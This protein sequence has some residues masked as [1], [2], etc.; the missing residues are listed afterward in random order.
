MRIKQIAGL[1]A[2]LDGLLS[3]STPNRIPFVNGAGDAYTDS[4]NLTFNSGT[5]TLF[6]NNI[7]LPTVGSTLSVGLG[8]ARLDIT[9]AAFTVGD[10]INYTFDYGTYLWDI[11]YNNTTIVNKV[12]AGTNNTNVFDFQ[13]SGVDIG[14]ITIG[15]EDGF[16]FKSATGYDATIQLTNTAD[17]ILFKQDVNT[18]LSISG[19]GTFDFQGSTL[20]NVAD[21]SNPQ[22][23]AT[24]NYVDNS[25]S[26][27]FDN[28]ADDNGNS[29][30]LGNLATAGEVALNIQGL[31]SNVD[32]NLNPQGTGQ[33]I[34]PNGTASKPGLRFTSNPTNTGIWG[35]L[36]SVRV[37]I[38]GG[39]QAIFTSSGVTFPSGIKNN[40]NEN[41]LTQT[42]QLRNIVDAR[43]G[44]TDSPS[45][46]SYPLSVYDTTRTYVASFDSTNSVYIDIGN[47]SSITSEAG[48]RIQSPTGSTFLAQSGSAST[49]SINGTSG[50][51]LLEFSTLGQLR[52]L[53]GVNETKI[54]HNLEVEGF[55]TDSNDNFAIEIDANQATFVQRSVANSSIV[56]N[57][58]SLDLSHA[59]FASFGIDAVT[60]SL[61]PALD[62]STFGVVGTQDTL[63]GGG[64]IFTGLNSSGTFYLLS[65]DE[66]KNGVIIGSR[67]SLIQNSVRNSVVIGG[68][69]INAAASNTLY[70]RNFEADGDL[71]Y[72]KMDNNHAALGI[73]NQANSGV[74]ISQE[75]LDLSH[76]QFV[77]FGVDAVTS[78]Q[79][80]DLDLS[81]YGFGTQDTLVGGG[82][83][84]TGLNDSGTFY[85]LSSDEDKNG[86]IIGSRNSVIQPNHKNTVIIGS[87]GI[88]SDASD[89][90][91]I[92][93]LKIVDTITKGN[94]A[95]YTVSPIITPNV[96]TSFLSNGGTLSMSPR[97]NLY[98]IN[99]SGNGTLSAPPASV[100]T[101]GHLMRLKIT[102]DGTSRTIT[103]GGGLWNEIINLP[104][105]TG[106][107]GTPIIYVTIIFNAD[108]GKWDVIDVKS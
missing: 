66:N 8:A 57:A 63:V 107:S 22:Q 23:V 2:A 80:N 85:L 65:S 11:S 72:L 77:S 102:D 21:P 87:S 76:S 24:K 73:I 96:V 82:E 105:S 60:S 67:N 50:T 59:Q 99:F 64:E 93:N 103:W 95:D 62:L 41:L 53:I 28:I 26:L 52:A 55:I 104:T 46:S 94:T 6:S 89:T 90:V 108:D 48:V 54:L 45:A 3:G 79:V 9:Q 70:T 91:Y 75:S 18:L 100:S 42:G 74:V 84:F 36:N 101:D 12:L 16:A 106:G 13:R 32:L 20:D 37:S 83:I 15:A 97:P 5:N 86:V 92:K 31:D 1:Q 71:G 25:N 35:N 68:S 47:T 44:N 34:L 40:I 98:K 61:V 49:F 4:S 19:T 88:K 51:N 81:A 78:S 38:F 27:Q 33:V 29:V 39:D 69:N 14:Q 56:L 17:S 7:S 58:E 10:S 30:L 43:I